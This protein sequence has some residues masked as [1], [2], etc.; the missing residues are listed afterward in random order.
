MLIAFINCFFYCR[1]DVQ[2]L[3]LVGVSI[4]SMA[5]YLAMRNSFNDRKTLVIYLLYSF[6]LGVM[7]C[8]SYMSYYNIQPFQYSLYERAVKWVIV[9][10]ISLIVLKNLFSLSLQIK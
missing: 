6:V 5:F 3:A 8:A 1:Y 4:F 10:L 9:C 7:N 2:I